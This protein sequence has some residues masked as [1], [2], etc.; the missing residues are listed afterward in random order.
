MD[1]KYSVSRTLSTLIKRHSDQENRDGLKSGI[2]CYIHTYVCRTY[3]DWRAS[4]SS[5]PRPPHLKLQLVVFF[6]IN[7]NNGPALRHSGL[8]KATIIPFQ[9]R[10]RICKWSLNYTWSPRNPRHRGGD[11]PGWWPC[12]TSKVFLFFTVCREYLYHSYVT[13][14]VWI[15]RK[16]QLTPA[17]DFAAFKSWLTSGPKEPQGP[18]TTNTAST[19]IGSSAQ[20]A[21]GGDSSTNT[22]PAYPS[23]F[24]HIVELITTGQPIPGIQEIPDTVLTGHDISSEKPRRRKP[25][26]KDDVGTADDT[27]SAAP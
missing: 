10:S 7:G 9:F 14:V 12:S 17:I 22:E 19:P 13:N 15:H 8:W 4:V 27:A 23:S 11:E 26:E 16:E 1:E 24:A 18:D 6:H 2:Y 5:A 21:H 20:I 25:W 3:V